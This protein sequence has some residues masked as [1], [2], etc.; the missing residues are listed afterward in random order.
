[1]KVFI[2]KQWYDDSIYISRI[3]NRN[4]YG[5]RK[6]INAQKTKNSRRKHYESTNNNN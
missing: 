1:M 2:L 4:I 3:E 6:V 5:K